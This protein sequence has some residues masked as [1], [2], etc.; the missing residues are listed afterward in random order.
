MDEG[1]G[2]LLEPLFVIGDVALLTGGLD[3]LKGL[4]DI[5]VGSHVTEVLEGLL[6]ILEVPVHEVVNIFYTSLL[7]RGPHRTF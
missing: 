7:A 4:S 3:T 5:L 6:C 2:L 1:C